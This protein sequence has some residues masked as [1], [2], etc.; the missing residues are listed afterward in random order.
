DPVRR[1]GAASP[2]VDSPDQYGAGRHTIPRGIARKSAGAFFAVQGLRRAG[3]RP[4][5]PVP[6]VVQPRLSATGTHQLADL[7]AGPGKVDPL[8]ISARNQWL[9]GLAAAPR[10]GSPLLCVLSSRA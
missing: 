1:G 10:S 4:A 2:G 5:A 3:L 6:V 8:R 9:A 7:R